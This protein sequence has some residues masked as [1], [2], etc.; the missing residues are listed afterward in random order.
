MTRIQ[1]TILVEGRY[2]ANKLRQIVETQVLETSGFGIFKN[3]EKRVLL[4]K[5]AAARGIVVL[6]DSDNAGFV[7]RNHLRGILP[8][9]QVKHAYI[10]QI[11][12][13]EKRKLHA[14]KEGLLGVEGISDALILDALRR[15]GATFLD[16]TVQKD[17]GKLN[18]TDFYTMGLSGGTQSKEL[19]VEMLRA[20]GLPVQMSANAMLE[21]VNLLFSREEFLKQLDAIRERVT[22][23]AS[24]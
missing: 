19:R 3:A 4:Q 9:E 22:E 20:L 23:D 8:R 7:I 10:P 5:I 17:S 11:V 14:S 15:A 1:E 6:T 2:D 16:E 24:H 12:G 21:A 13:K 18:K